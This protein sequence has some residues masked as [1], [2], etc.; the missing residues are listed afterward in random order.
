MIASKKSVKHYHQKQI[1]KRVYLTRDEII[2]E[3]FKLQ[4]EDSELSGFELFEHLIT[5]DVVLEYSDRVKDARQFRAVDVIKVAVGEEDEVNGV[6]L[7]DMEIIVEDKYG[8]IDTIKANGLFN[9]Y[10][11]GKI[12]MAEIPISEISDEPLIC[13][14]KTLGESL[15]EEVSSSLSE[16]DD[17][18][19]EN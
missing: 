6:V 15:G 9:V 16:E 17:S 8:D 14:G 3:L 10:K 7:A 12:I 5:H 4:T 2:N 19:E 18:E 13:F 1:S 11:I